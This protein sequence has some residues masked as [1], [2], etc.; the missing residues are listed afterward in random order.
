MMGVLTINLPGAYPMYPLTGATIRNN[1]LL[2]G[3]GNYVG[4]KRGAFWIYAGSTSISN[5]TFQDNEILNP[6]FSAIHLTGSGKQE[7]VFERN[8]IENPGED[9]IVIEPPVNG[10]GTFRNNTVVG[11][12]PNFKAIANNGG[13]DYTVAN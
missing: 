4:Q 7:M 11:L 8:R 12:G 5:V 1:T 13:S 3:S 10:S 6:V 9:G 2:R